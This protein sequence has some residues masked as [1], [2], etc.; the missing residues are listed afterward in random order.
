MKFPAIDFMSKN[1]H[2]AHIDRKLVKAKL[3]ADAPMNFR[4]LAV[5]TMISYY[6]VCT[7]AKDPNFPDMDGL[8]RPSAFWE[9]FNA[10]AKN[11]VAQRLH[12]GEPA[13]A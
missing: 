6:R 7:L 3:K 9:F 4:E 2:L 8:I 11:A 1:Q 12:Q 13:T 5:A 10:R